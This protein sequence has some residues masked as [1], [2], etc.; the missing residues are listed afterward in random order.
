MGMTH[1]VGLPELSLKILIEL[2]ENTSIL[3][4]LIYT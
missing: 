1:L 4:S 3:I 2:L